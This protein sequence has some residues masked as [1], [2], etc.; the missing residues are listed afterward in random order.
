MSLRLAVRDGVLGKDEEVKEGDEV[1]HD[2]SRPRVL[3]IVAKTGIYF[4]PAEPR[5]HT[6]PGSQR[7][8][9][10]DYMTHKSEGQIMV[11]TSLR[12]RLVLVIALRFGTDWDYAEFRQTVERHCQ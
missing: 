3:E 5:S 8:R 12:L 10:R 4:H 2:E 7:E 6:T 9:E 11:K 1:G